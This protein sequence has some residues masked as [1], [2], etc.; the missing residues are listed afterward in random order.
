MASNEAFPFPQEDNDR[1]FIS[2]T[3]KQDYEK[4][5]EVLFTGGIADWAKKRLD[6]FGDFIVLRQAYLEWPDPTEDPHKVA[7]VEHYGQDIHPE[8]ASIHHLICDCAGNTYDRQPIFCSI[9]QNAVLERASY[10]SRTW[11]IP[12]VLALYD[13]L[14]VSD[15]KR[16]EELNDLLL[17]TIEKILITDRNHPEE[18]VGNIV[19]GEH[20]VQLMGEILQQPEDTVRMCAEILQLQDKL[21]IDGDTLRLA[22]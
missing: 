17:H 5:I 4:Y 14:E 8:S 2:L 9:A 7:W 18:W 13:D 3:E 6:H 12:E 16:N 15:Y 1:L 11:H 10:T 20:E 22:A 19:S 21:E